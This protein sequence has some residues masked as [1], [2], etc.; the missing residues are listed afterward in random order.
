MKKINVKFQK[1]LPYSIN[2]A[3]KSLRTN[4][5][6]CGA[7]IRCIA[8]TSCLPN[9]GKSSVT[10]ELA[11]SF[12]EI[13]K[14]VLLIDTDMRNSVLA[15]KYTE[16]VRLNGLSEYLIGRLPMEEVI[17]QTQKEN[18]DIIFSG[19]FPPNPVELLNSTFF[20]ELLSTAREQYDYVLIDTPPLGAII[21]A[22]VVAPL[23]DG[24]ILVLASDRISHKLAAKVKKQLEGGNSKVLGVVLNMVDDKK[25]Y[26]IIKYGVYRYNKYKYCDYYSVRGDRKSAAKS[27]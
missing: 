19:P 13:G 21:D 22:A 5:Q 6:F 9:E 4:L 25:H 23:C 26:H 7:G 20:T 3:F 8:L 17:Y 14:R 1:D 16:E 2:E 10:L 15:P 18:L 11:K 27:K 24:V 12:S